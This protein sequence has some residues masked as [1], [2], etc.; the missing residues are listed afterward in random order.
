MS[1]LSAVLGS[2]GGHLRHGAAWSDWSRARAAH[3]WLRFLYR[4]GGWRQRARWSAAVRPDHSD[5]RRGYRRFLA[6]A[7][8]DVLVFLRV[9]RYVEFYGPQRLLA[10]RV[11]GLRAV[12][13]ARFGWGL[14]AG[15]PA[16]QA[17]RFAARALGAGVAVVL[18]RAHRPAPLLLL[19]PTVR[20]PSSRRCAWP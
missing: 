20:A 17:A 6:A 5:P 13:L 9:G 11:L 1:A 19:P 18:P 8:G 7:E 4:D 16:W 14:T 10:E 2:Y 15:F 12:P 3:G